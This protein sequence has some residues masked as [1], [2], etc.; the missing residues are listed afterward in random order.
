MPD[1][2]PPDPLLVGTDNHSAPISRIVAE[3]A[4]SF[5][6]ERITLG[7]MV[8]AFGERAFGVL[9]LLLCLPSLLPGMATVFGLPMLLLGAQMGM[10]LRT[11]RLPAF[12]ARQSIKRTDLLRLAN[13]S[14][15]GLGRVE[16]YLRPRPGWFVSAMGER[17]VGWLTV[18][19]AIML[20][21]PGPGTNGPPAFGTIVMALGV[22]EQDSRVTGLGVGLAAAGCLLATGILVALC[23]FGV[24]AL[25]WI[26]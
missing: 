14:S 3:V 21:L 7:N 19:T 4:A 23:W 17:L 15:R 18:Y 22:V 16:R 5:P 9:I 12:M 20:I 1:H 6:G 25:G 10:G 26:F 13:A 11:P 2:L 24:A 8:E